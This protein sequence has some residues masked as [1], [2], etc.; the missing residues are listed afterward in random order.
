MARIVGQIIA[1]GN[2]RWLILVYL[3]PIKL[4]RWIFALLRDLQTKATAHDLC[5][6]AH[7]SIFRTP[8]GRQSVPIISLSISD[9]YSTAPVCHESGS[10]ICATRWPQSSWQPECRQKLSLSSSDMPA[11]PSRWTLML[12]CYRACRTRL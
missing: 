11:R 6:E 5:P 1:Q 9:R 4:Q 12:T 10:T 2:R 3:G 7:D 8:W